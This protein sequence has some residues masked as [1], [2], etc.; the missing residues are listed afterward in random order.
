ML[1][2]EREKPLSDV[3]ASVEEHYTS[4]ISVGQLCPGQKYIYRYK[5]EMGGFT[6]YVTTTLQ[7][8]KVY[9]TDDIVLEYLRDEEIP[10]G[11]RNIYHPTQRRYVFSY[12]GDEVKLTTRDIIPTDESI[13]NGLCEEWKS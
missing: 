12:N 10:E 4:R 1:F 3:T 8:P 11:E 9:G 6:A 13:V 5:R 7:M 2:P